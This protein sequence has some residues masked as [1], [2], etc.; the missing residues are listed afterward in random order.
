MTL[1]TLCIAAFLLAGTPAL[2]AG[3]DDEFCP[4]G[5]TQQEMNSCAADELARADTAL[6]AAY[7]EVLR[8]VEPHRVEP[9][10]AAQRAWIRFR[11]A[12]CEFEASEFAGGSMEPMMHT[13][14]LA[15]LTRRR[16]EEF[17]SIL[18]EGG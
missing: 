8:V 15:H 16:T 6:N 4:D 9:L 17:D 7:Q 3:Q 1:R 18:N 2:L 13:L 11:D 14:C 12:E 10:R 5:R